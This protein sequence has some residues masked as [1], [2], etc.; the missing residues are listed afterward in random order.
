MKLKPATRAFYDPIYRTN[1]YVVICGP[2]VF[3]ERLRV[4]V[5][6]HAGASVAKEVWEKCHHTVEDCNG[7]AYRLE[8]L[9]SA[10]VAHICV[11]F[12]RAGADVSVVSHE[13]WHAVRWVFNHRGVD[14]NDSGSD[15]AAAYYL[16]WLVRAALG[17]PV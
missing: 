5:R 1:Y 11:I 7:R 14:L 9:K 6:R 13:A 17:I 2:D 4:L 8:A 12:L 3:R 10:V 16:Q 15:E